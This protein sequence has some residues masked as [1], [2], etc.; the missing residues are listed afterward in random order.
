MRNLAVAF[1]LL[2]SVYAS[3]QADV[4][5]IVSAVQ[6]KKTR[7]VPTIFTTVGKQERQQSRK[8]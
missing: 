3:T 4:L 7:G 1:F 8:M 2:V 5:N 6:Q